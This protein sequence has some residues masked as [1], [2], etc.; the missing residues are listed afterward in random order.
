MKTDHISG[1]GN[2]RLSNTEKNK[3]EI[4]ET[5]EVKEKREDQIVAKKKS[6]KKTQTVKKYGNHLDAVKKMI[7]DNIQWRELRFHR[8]E[9]NGKIYVDV[10]NKNSGEVIR[11][12]PETDFVKFSNKYK[13]LS[14]LNINIS[15]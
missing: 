6:E 8:H 13:E 5:P 2:V 3:K 15:G 9:A 4:K 11:T 7:G 1:K 14:G 10:I 12:V